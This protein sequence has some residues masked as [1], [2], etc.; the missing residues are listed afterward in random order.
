MRKFYDYL[1]IAI[2]I[3]FYAMLLILSTLCYQIKN[4]RYLRGNEN[5]NYKIHK[6]RVKKFKMARYAMYFLYTFHH[7]WGQLVDNSRN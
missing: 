3:L 6:Q 1:R 4:A 2:R 5:K 7:C